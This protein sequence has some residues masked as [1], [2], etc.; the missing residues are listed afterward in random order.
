MRKVLSFLLCLFLTLSLPL[1]LSGCTQG[2][3]LAYQ[4]KG[5][6]YQIRYQGP[7]GEVACALC[8][9][10]GDA[11]RDFRLSFP[12][13]EGTPA[14]TIAQ[15]DGAFWLEYHTTRVS[16]SPP[17]I[18]EDILSLFSIPEGARV[19]AVTKEGDTRVV[20]LVAEDTIYTLHFAGKSEIPCYISAENARFISIY[21]N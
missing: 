6:D 7:S 2:S 10:A 17:P 4:S 3:I 14:Y 21:V 20:T 13:T 11:T 12:A 1:S 19:S 8:L 5:G 18:C 9:G 16:I 15:S